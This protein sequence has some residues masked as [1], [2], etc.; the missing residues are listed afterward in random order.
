MPQLIHLIS[1]PPRV[2]LWAV[3]AILASCTSS[4]TAP[5]ALLVSE[6]YTPER[7]A[8]ELSIG[9]LMIECERHLRTW[10]QAF[11]APRTQANRDAIAFTERAISTLVHREQSKL[12]VEA[13]SGPPRNRGLAS[14][15]LGFSG[16]PEVLSLIASNVSSDNE[17]VASNALLGLGILAHKETPLGPI[18][19]AVMAHGNSEPIIQ[20][21]AYAALRLADVAE[22]D[23]QGSMAAI[24][25]KLISHSNSKVRGQAVIGL[26]LL[27]TAH[28]LPLIST[29][30]ME[31]EVARVRTGAAWALGEIGDLSSIDILID[32]LDDE[33]PIVAG[34]ARASLVKLHGRDFGQEAD[35][36]RQVLHAH[37]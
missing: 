2:T 4:S 20:N 12:E 5:G 31:D 8:K 21:A 32:S 1:T 30:L 37:R 17:M 14:A 25:V 13:V 33:D 18:Y 36:W 22:D 19:A 6:P 23:S 9:Q 24:F 15:A 29:R 16:D 35:E 28:A 34:T 11:A 3:L 10:E 27:R 26:G 7:P